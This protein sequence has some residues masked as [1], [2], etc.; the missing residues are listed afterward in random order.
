GGGGVAQQA[1]NFIT[2]S[3]LFW[4]LFVFLFSYLGALL[5]IWRYTQP[6]NYIGFWVT[7]L[8][9]VF[10]WLGAALSGVGSLLN[11]G[12]L[13]PQVSQFTLPTFT[14]LQPLAPETGMI[15]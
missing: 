13:S 4:V 8:T 15:Q 7:A 12:F 10:S 9:I 3:L 2:P 6:V 14:G 5:P 1:T 11:L